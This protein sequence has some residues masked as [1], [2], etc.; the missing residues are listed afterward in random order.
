MPQ[1]PTSNPEWLETAIQGETKQ[2]RGILQQLLH[3]LNQ[4]LTGLQCSLEVALAAPRTAEHYVRTLQE[5]IEL[6]GRMR[7]LV[8][9]IGEVATGQEPAGSRNHDKD[10]ASTFALQRLIEEIVAQLAP[11][12]EAVDVRMAPTFSSVSSIHVRVER[13]ALAEALFRLLESAVSLAR[14]DGEVRIEARGEPGMIA[15]RIEWSAATAWGTF[16]SAELGVLVAQASL[17]HA[18]LQCERHGSGNSQSV[19]IRLPVA[20][21]SSAAAGGHL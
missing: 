10:S 2:E 6:T 9:A 13:A 7:A 3:A 12:A 5:G 20:A 18:G 1:T 14:P 17:A 4:P 15:V 16:S 8:G 11:V 21:A 19:T